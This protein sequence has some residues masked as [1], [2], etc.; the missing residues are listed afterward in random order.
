MEEE[1]RNEKEEEVWVREKREREK[2]DEEKTTRN[3]ERRMKK[4]KGGAGKESGGDD[5]D[6]KDSGGKIKARV[7]VKEGME[8]LGGEGVEEGQNGGNV[9]ED[10]G[11]IIHDDD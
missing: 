7:V 9:V 3:R 11:V 1:V 8:G 6:M 10:V 5:V 4:R 2:R